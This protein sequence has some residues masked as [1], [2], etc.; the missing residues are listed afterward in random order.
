MG[1]V[2]LTASPPAAAME[3]S[4]QLRSLFKREPST[5]NAFSLGFPAETTC[6]PGSLQATTEHRSGIIRTCHFW[7][8]STHS[9]CTGPPPIPPPPPPP[10]PSPHSYPM[11]GL[12]E[13]FSVVLSSL[14]F[15]LPN[16]SSFSLS[17]HR[18][19]INSQEVTTPTACKHSCS[20]SL[21]TAL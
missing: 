16:P 21:R 9:L 4:E 6:L 17:F 19:H 12:A 18:G 15:S 7:D 14:M 2:P 3:S 5:S 13:T 1:K 10:P 11:T 8:F 20:G